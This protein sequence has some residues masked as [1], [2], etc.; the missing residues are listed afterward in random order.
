MDLPD[1]KGT[2]VKKNIYNAIWDKISNLLK[3]EFNSMPVC[4]NKLIRIKKN[5]KKKWTPILMVLLVYL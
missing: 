3:R 5:T 4:D 2:N 1:N